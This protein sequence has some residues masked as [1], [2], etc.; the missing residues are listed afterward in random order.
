MENLYVH[1]ARLNYHRNYH[2]N[3]EIRGSARLKH[4]S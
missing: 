4:I 3:I 2:R 1:F